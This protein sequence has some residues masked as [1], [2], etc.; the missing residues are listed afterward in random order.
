MV[1]IFGMTLEAISRPFDI[2]S[3]KLFQF[4][5]FSFYCL[6]WILLCRYYL[7]CYLCYVSFKK[8]LRIFPVTLRSFQGQIKITNVLLTYCVG[9]P[10]SNCLEIALILLFF[11][12]S[13]NLDTM[14]CKL[15]RN[16][17]CTLFC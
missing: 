15:N 11:Q 4:C 2:E 7:K 9:F 17:C 6:I 1:D 10:F 5:C 16:V 12:V 3:L 14:T 13:F 8:S